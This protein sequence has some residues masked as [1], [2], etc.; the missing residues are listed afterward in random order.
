MDR[1]KKIAVAIA[2]FMA[3]SAAGLGMASA[4][5][6]A[7]FPAQQAQQ[8]QQAAASPREQGLQ[9]IHRLAGAALRD[10]EFRIGD[11]IRQQACTCRC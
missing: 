2:A 11:R 1:A 10:Q 5:Y 9:R 8:T 6:A 3:S 7:P 4:T